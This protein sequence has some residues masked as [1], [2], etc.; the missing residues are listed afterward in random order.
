MSDLKN[1]IKMIMKYISKKNRSPNVQLS[2]CEVIIIKQDLFFKNHINN[3][4][5][6]S[7]SNDKL[8]DLYSDYC[9]NNFEKKYNSI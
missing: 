1:T 5:A 6:R 8:T 3:T 4:L 9:V 2:N 7:Y